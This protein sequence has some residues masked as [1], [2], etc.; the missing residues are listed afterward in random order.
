VFSVASQ[1]SW[2]F[3]DGPGIRMPSARWE[4]R[5]SGPVISF[6]NNGT[7]VL[8]ER[9]DDLATLEKSQRATAALASGVEVFPKGGGSGG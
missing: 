9:A 7:A 3:S 6:A 5:P 1:G 4:E 8:V 2:G